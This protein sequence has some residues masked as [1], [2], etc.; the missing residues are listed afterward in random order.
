MIKKCLREKSFTLIELIIVITILGIIAGV[1]LPL[2]LQLIDS[3]SYS[4]Y[5]RDLS[6]SADAALR[7]MSR[8]IRRLR[9]DSSVNIA[10]ATTY[11][12]VVNEGTIQF[13]LNGNDLERSFDGNTD[14]LISDVSFFSFKYLDD[15]G[16]VIAAPLVSPDKTDIKFIEINMTLFSGDNTIYYIDR[17]RPRNVVHI[18]DLFS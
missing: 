2:T 6:E 10:S 12:F 4:L 8:E 9:D 3:F 1:G 14:A 15:E 7:R 16:S 13:Q 5:R 18:P 11:A 17:I